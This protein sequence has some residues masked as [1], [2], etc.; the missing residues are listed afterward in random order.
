MTIQKQIIRVASIILILLLI[1][2]GY[3]LYNAKQNIKFPPEISE[4]PDYWKVNG[5]EV[6]ENVK[7]LGSCSGV[8]DFSGAEWQGKTG[9]K[10]KYD[11]SRQ[12]GIVWD[13]I[14]NNPLF[15]K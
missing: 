10:K 1:M 4:C 6:C 9:M 14:T 8:H 5:I 12:C 3:M 7:G 2:I 13:G 15:S 11:W